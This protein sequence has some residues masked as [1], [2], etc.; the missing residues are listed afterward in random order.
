M[1]RA[2]SVLGANA[3]EAT[4][5]LRKAKLRTALGLVG[6]MI[7]ISSV[8]VMVSL[9]E[10]AKAQA[11]KQ[12]EA[13]GTDIML[14]RKSP[15]APAPQGRRPAT[16]ALS[17]AIRLAPE[18]PS[19]VETAPR[20]SGHG[21]FR[22]AGREVSDGRIQGV[23]A[24]FA[25]VNRLS[26][27]AGRFISDLDVDRY[28]C[29]IGADIADAMRRAGARRLVGEI[30]EVGEVL[31]TIV[32]VLNDATENYVLP[33]QVGANGSVFVP[34]T[35]SG[36]VVS[37]PEIEVVIARS[38]AGVHHETAVADVRSFFRDRA[39][40]LDLEIIAA[41]DLIARLEAQV[42]NYT[43]LLAAVGSIALIVGGIGIM[44]IML[45]SVAERRR[46]IAVRRA[47]GARRR[48][49]QSQFL[50]ESVILT[51]AGGVLG[52]L[53]GLAVTWGICRF[54]GWEFL[55]SGLSVASGLGT[56]TAAGLFFGFQPARQ[57][58]R[59]DPIAGLQGD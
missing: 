41:K 33:V 38:R 56:A 25:S 27:Q 57:A 19:I 3:R 4:D 2:L 24:S 32:G 18:V 1:S 55:V 11:R 21:T 12:F 22:H 15:H 20:V 13:L 51:T 14:M 10:I 59:L 52:V 6:I 26:V 23:T 29:V 36:R 5:S 44:N 39:P 35:T 43:L 58:S 8:I 53:L 46:E 49:I 30:V 17:D 50:I 37:E 7:G 42:R 31:F 45:V 54:T 47:L 48:D 34:I 28:W 16:M 40:D 9:G